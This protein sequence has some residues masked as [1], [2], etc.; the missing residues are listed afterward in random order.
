MEFLFSGFIF[1]EAVN[2]VVEF[3]WI[4]VIGPDAADVEIIRNSVVEDFVI[5]LPEYIYYFF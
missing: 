2:P 4:H 5:F 3:I 1:V